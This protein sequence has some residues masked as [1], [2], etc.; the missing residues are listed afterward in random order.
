MDPLHTP[1]ELERR[2]RDALLR[3][4]DPIGVQEF[5]EAH[6]EYDSFVP[7]VCRLLLGGANREEL[8]S[9]LW[10]VETEHMSLRG[11]RN[12]T[13]DFADRLMRLV[14]EGTRP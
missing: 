9:F 2:V 8:L 10:S 13:Q 4:W 5:P 11:D 12:R 1:Q 7:A 14:N 3:D 6:S